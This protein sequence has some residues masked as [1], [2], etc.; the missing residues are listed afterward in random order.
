[1]KKR[2][3]AA[4]LLLCLCP[5]AFADMDVITES[6]YD[7]IEEKLKGDI[8]NLTDPEYLKK[9]VTA[10]ADGTSDQMVQEIVDNY[11]PA[12]VAS[13]AGMKLLEKLVP[14]AA[15]PIELILMASDIAHKG[16]RNWLDWAKANR[17]AEFN[18]E[19]IEK[20]GE[21]VTGLDAAWNNFTADFIYTGLSDTGVLYAER[22]DLLREMK[23]AYAMRRKELLLAEQKKNAV[24]A[25]IEAKQRAY[26]YLR[27]LKAD[28]RIKAEGVVS[29]LKATGQ[30]PTRDSVRKALKDPKFY[31]ELVAKWRT[32]VDKAADAKGAVPPPATGDPE[33]DKAAAIVVASKRDV[34]ENTLPDYGPVLQEYTLNADRLLAGNITPSEYHSVQSALY[35][36]ARNMLDAG[37]KPTY[38][39]SRDPEII[40]QAKKQIE[41][42]QA[43]FEKARAGIEAVDA[44]LTK[45]A[46]DLKKELEALT[47]GG[48]GGGYYGAKQNKPL[49]ELAEKYGGELASSEPGKKLEKAEGIIYDLGNSN[50]HEAHSRWTGTD[51]AG[52]TAPTLEQMRRFRDTFADGAAALEQLR[53]MAA[54]RAAL[55]AGKLLDFEKEYNASSGKYSELLQGNSAL[56]EYAAIKPY[57][58]SRQRAELTYARGLAAAEKSFAS[59]A[60]LNSLQQSALQLRREQKAWDEELKANDAYLAEFKT[61]PD[62]AAA[63]IKGGGAGPADLTADTLNKYYAE[64][65]SELVGLIDRSAL[66]LD[67]KTRA[68][69]ASQVLYL[70]GESLRASELSASLSLKTLKN[71]ADRAGELKKMIETLKA[72]DIEGRAAKVAALAAAMGQAAGKIAVMS[73]EAGETRQAFE[74]ARSRLA[75]G[76]ITCRTASKNTACLSPAALEEKLKV[77]QARIAWAEGQEKKCAAACA[78]AA[79]DLAYDSRPDCSLIRDKWEM[80][81]AAGTACAAESKAKWASAQKEFAKYNPFKEVTV[82]GRQLDWDEIKLARADLKGG[83]AVISGSLNSDAPAYPQIYVSLNGDYKSREP[84]QTVPV[85]G[86]RFEFSFAPVPGETYYV[87]VQGINGPG[88]MDSM[89]RPARGYV[90]VTL[91]A[92]DRTAE[93]QAFYEK[94]RAAYEGRNAAQVMALISPDW[95]AGGDDTTLEDLEENLRTN[96]RL[97]DEIRFSF[98]GLRVTQQGAALQACYDTVITSRIFKRNLKHEEKAA[99]CDELKE[100]G[101]KLRITRTLSGRYWY[102]K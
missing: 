45:R 71:H 38:K 25:R 75:E 34:P 93:A 16:T 41:Q 61:S 86:G 78:R 48:P 57:D 77:Y 36:S 31:N 6:V 63:L 102:V 21:T 59:Q 56:A 79:S 13:E 52:K 67:E 33:L 19:V 24:R 15:G 58:F 51:W 97:Y 96:F 39:Y 40:A 70:D 55:F 92:E 17:V 68:G 46:Q 95:G 87:G 1:M 18:S 37:L 49:T 73:L 9:L 74:A 44:S 98:S 83:K 4:A 76:L 60:W 30:Q 64:E 65:L 12:S 84:A 66:L 81:L 23:T 20:G 8:G 69:D 11:D 82:S 7:V 5:R 27:W 99:V 42:Q 80:S 3:L 90:K 94:F 14:A 28:A 22:P 72:A 43:A 26:K 54:E 91:A 29:M 50:C 53:P 32:E 35:T 89:P 101:G 62:K 2:I 88:G 85:T 100:E 47:M 10:V